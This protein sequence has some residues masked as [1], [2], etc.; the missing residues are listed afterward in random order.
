M[1]TE[2]RARVN[3]LGNEV[4][5]AIR[6]FIDGDCEKM[7]GEVEAPQEIQPFEEESLASYEVRIRQVN[8]GFMVE[9]GCQTFVFE[10]FEKM[11][12]YMKM[13]FDNPQ[14][15]TKLHYDKKLFV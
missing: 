6:D 1:N 9:V 11:S 15:T 4:I 2:T 13:Y 3:D 8:N 14:E 12:K 7:C 5:D 10:S